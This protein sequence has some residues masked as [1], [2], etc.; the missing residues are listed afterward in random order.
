VQDEQVKIYDTTLRDGTQ[1]EDVSFSVEDKLRIAHALD[2]L[3]IAYIEGGWPGSNPRDAAFFEAARREKLTQA[4]YTA[5]GSTRR[6]GVAASA[7]PLLAALLA[8]GVE[9]A[10]IFGKSWSL[11]ARDALGVSLEENLELIFDTV[12]FLK[13][14]VREV[15]YDAEH[16]FDGYADSPEYALLTLQ[17]AVDAGA[18]V[19]VLCDTNGGTMPH[20]VSAAVSR[21]VQQFPT[22]VVGIHAHNDGEVAVA[23]TLAAVQAGARHV[24]GTI[25][26]FGERC[27]NANLVSIIPNLQ[28]KL[29]FACVPEAQLVNLKSTS[30]LMFELLNAPPNKRQPYVGDSAFAHKGGIHVSA[31]MKNARTYEHIEPAKVGNR[32]RVLVSDLSGRSNVVY[33]AKEWGVDLDSKDVETKQILTQLKE[34]E[35]QGFEFEGAEASFELLV[36]EAKNPGKNASFR[37]LGFRVIAEKRSDDREPLAEAT[38]QIEVDG[39]VEHTAALGNGPVNALD[40]AL[41]KALEKFYPELKSVHLVDYKVRVL[42]GDKGTATKVRVLLESADAEGRWGTVGVSDNILEASYQ[43]LVD[44]IRYKLFKDRRAASLRTPP[45]V[46]PVST[47]VSAP[48]AARSEPAVRLAGRS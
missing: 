45:P 40:M 48:P 19:V 21:V 2:D 15:V 5:F 18:D 9:V 39:H 7:D 8:T 25:N 29:G 41:R 36:H 31:V 24:Q 12:A 43:A 17:S 38:V 14:H 32:R 23:N 6:S 10:C 34:L 11:H 26:G 46:L 4:R 27:G 47:P 44:S 30:R 35:S 42:G 22:L 28:L 37:L 33:K 16:F 20:L 3:G 13:K 1:A